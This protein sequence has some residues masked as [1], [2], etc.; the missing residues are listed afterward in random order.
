L[1]GIDVTAVFLPD[2]SK[3]KLRDNKQLTVIKRFSEINQR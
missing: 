2:I 3:I 1:L